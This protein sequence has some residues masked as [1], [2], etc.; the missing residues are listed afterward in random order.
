MTSMSGTPSH[1]ATLIKPKL[2]G[3]LFPEHSSRCAPIG[4]ARP[5]QIVNG[6]GA[7]SPLEAR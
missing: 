4:R 1:S 6:H 7:H 2:A 5:H 3:L